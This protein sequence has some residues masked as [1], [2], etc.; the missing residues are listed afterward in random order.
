MP[1]AS[2]DA[3]FMISFSD[4]GVLKDQEEITSTK[5]LA[6]HQ[7]YLN[8]VEFD[9][10]VE[11]INRLAIRYD[12]IYANAVVIEGMSVASLEHLLILKLEALTSRGHSSKGD[13]DRRDIAKIGLLLG[14]RANVELILP[15]LHESLKNELR[16]VARSTVFYDLVD[17]NAHAAKKARA[18]FATFAKRL[19]T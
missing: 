11:K 18:A 12:E 2:H 15:H 9:I 3:D 14:R 17:Q 7:M 6:K 10:Y 19:S 16:D 4:Y 13:K 1:E 5:R 8:N